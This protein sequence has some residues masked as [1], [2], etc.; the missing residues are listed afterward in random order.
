[1]GRAE[2][3]R[4]VEAWSQYLQQT[5][6]PNPSAAPLVANAY[7]NLA[8]S[9]R[10][11]EEAETNVEGAA[12]AQRIAAEARP[13][14]GSLS[15]LAIYEYYSGNFAAGDSATKKAAGMAS[16]SEAK[17]VK[18]QLAEFRKRGEAFQKQKR[19]VAKLEQGQGK[20]A[21]QNPFGGLAG[22]TGS[23]GE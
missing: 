14:L 22:S 21:L 7:F 10:T 6:S 12:A 20:E 1:E 9:S 4:A 8:E 15:T 2:L 23:L 19:E 18:K 17:E 11:L 5:D 13:S 16:K 3:N